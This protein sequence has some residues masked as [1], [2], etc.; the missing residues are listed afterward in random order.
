MGYCDVCDT[1]VKRRIR[2]DV[3]R[4]DQELDSEYL[5]CKTCFQECETT[6]SGKNCKK[7]Q[8]NYLLADKQ[9]KRR[10]DDKKRK[11]AIMAA[12]TKNPKLFPQVPTENPE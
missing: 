5:V 7:Y 11:L 8:K 9:R 4:S 3:K 10:D 6:T 1:Y 2:L 12:R